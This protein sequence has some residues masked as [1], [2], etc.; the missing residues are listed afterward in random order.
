[1]ESAAKA[2]PTEASHAASNLSVLW[3]ALLLLLQTNAPLRSHGV[4]VASI[5]FVIG[6]MRLP[7]TLRV[8][9]LVCQVVALLCK[10]GAGGESAPFANALTGRHMLYLLSVCRRTP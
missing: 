5:G 2:A 10:P 9:E 6:T 7:V 8:H 3:E 4:C 1:M